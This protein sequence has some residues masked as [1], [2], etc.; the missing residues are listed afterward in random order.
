MSEL[1][2]LGSGSG[3][4]TKDRFCTSI[5][6]LAEPD[7]YLFD[8]GE[9]CAALLFRHGIDSLALKTLFVSHMHPDHVGGLAAL[10]FSIYLPGRSSKVKFRPWSVNRN[11]PWYRA[12]LSFP[13]LPPGAQTVEES[14]SLI[15][16]VMPSEAIEPIRTY[17]PAVYLAPSILPFDL[18]Y[19]PVQEGIT[20]SDATVKVT[21][22][23]NTHL[24]A[25]RA[26][27]NLPAHHPHIALQSYSYAVETGG[28]KFVYSGDITTLNELNP[29][30][31]GAQLLIV[32]V[33]HYDPQDIGPFVRDLPLKRIVLTHVHPGLE[34]RLPELIKTWNDPRIEIA[35]DGMRIPLE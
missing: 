10:L 23:P 3:F 32:E 34:A 4:A 20:Y 26:H 33:A 17:L 22:A 14:R 2:I 30:L 24:S 7:L 25:N 9:P 29:L 8:C 15:H 28:T 12:Q 11:D 35:H 27:A 6:L 5:A 18:E 31:Q 13:K 21:A 16:L 19:S 1:V